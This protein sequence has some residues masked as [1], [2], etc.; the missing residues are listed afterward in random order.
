MQMEYLY[1]SPLWNMNPIN[2]FPKLAATSNA[3]IFKTLH[4]IQYLI[5]V[6]LLVLQDGHK[7]F[8]C[9][10]QLSCQII[11]KIVYTLVMI[12]SLQELILPLLSNSSPGL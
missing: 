2:I 6:A 4:G 11:N 1:C 5:I 7:Y 9:S 3:K 10:S 12:K 8:E